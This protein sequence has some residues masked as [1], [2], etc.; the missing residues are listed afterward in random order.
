MRN[1]VLVNKPY[2]GGPEVHGPYTFD[3]AD[4]LLRAGAAKQGKYDASCGYWS[5]LPCWWLLRPQIKKD[6]PVRVV[7][8][9]LNPAPL[10]AFQI[11]SYFVRLGGI[12]NVYYLCALLHDQFLDCEADL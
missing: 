3:E 8:K 7:K 10:C 1:Y 6:L 11:V 4:K 2:D 5:D 12:R 9:I